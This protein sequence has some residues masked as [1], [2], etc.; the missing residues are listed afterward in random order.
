M[1]IIG[2]TVVKIGK[3]ASA[4]PFVSFSLQTRP[5]HCTVD[6]IALTFPPQCCIVKSGI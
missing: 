1:V 6:K 2:K 4:R 5:N 3:Q